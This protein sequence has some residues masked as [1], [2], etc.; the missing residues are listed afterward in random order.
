[1]TKIATIYDAIVDILEA[2]LTGYTRLPNPYFVDKNVFLYLQ[3]GFGIGIGPGVDTE[4]YTGCLISWERTFNIILVNQITTTQNN[5]ASREFIEKALIDDHDAL[6][7][8]FYLNSSLNQNAI[9]TS[10]ISD[11]GISFID[12]E[13]LK[14]LGLEMTLVVEYQEDPNS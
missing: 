2:E 4:R 10:I 1:M 3:K 6:R 8:A 12:T 7:K 9:K 14:F 13:T 11:S 5:M